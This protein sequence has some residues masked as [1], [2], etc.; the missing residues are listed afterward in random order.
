LK[1]DSLLPE[2]ERQRDGLED[3]WSRRA[4]RPRFEQEL[5]LFGR[6]VR[7]LSN[8]EGPLAA[9][10]LCRPQY[11]IAPQAWAAPF[12]IQVIVGEARARLG[13]PPNN[14]IDYVQYTAD[15][16]WMS[17]LLGGWGQCQIDLAGG[18][19][20]ASLTP[21]L[22]HRP[23]L[24]AQC[25]LNTILTNLFMA[26]GLGMLHATCL[27]RGDHALLLIAPHNSGK[28]STALR[29]VLSGWRLLSDS[30]VYVPPPATHPDMPLMGFPVGRIKLREDM[31]GEFPEFG[32]LLSAEQV[33]GETKYTLDL[34]R[35]RPDLVERTAVTPAALDAC[36][37][38]RG[39]GARAR[40]APVDPAEVRAAVV[41][42]S[43]QR[44]TPAVWRRNL[45]ALEPLVAQ[46]RWR[47]LEIGASAD[48]IVQAVDTLAAGEQ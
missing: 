9:A 2:Y 14:L 35:F 38:S 28:S 21:E 13:P 22:A 31:L 41:A 32:P 27:L 36:L 42:N 26:H 43:L 1:P 23:D 15:G 12:T 45:A 24:I 17:M 29:L 16:D 3:F 34:G 4:S 33:R 10:E 6:P 30:Q 46:A 19:A 47:R 8:H 5:C 48:G 11:S 40:L 39:S 25:L 37:L 7:L 44:H 20:L 18:R